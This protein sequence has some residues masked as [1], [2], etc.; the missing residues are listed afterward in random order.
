MLLDGRLIQQGREEGGIGGLAVN[1]AVVERL[2]AGLARGA[3]EER[4]RAGQREALR[5][6]GLWQPEGEGVKFFFFK[7]TRRVK[8][9]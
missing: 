3:A 4:L 9:R 5:V 8:E 2:R 1:T 7:K 6:A